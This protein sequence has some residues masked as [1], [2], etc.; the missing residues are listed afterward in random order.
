MAISVS[1]SYCE[2]TRDERNRRKR[3]AVLQVTGLTAGV[4]NIVPH[5]L[6]MN[7]DQFSA[8]NIEPTSA[9]PF[10]EYQPADLTNL[11]IHAGGAGTACNVVVEY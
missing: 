7:P 6:P 10:S 2:A 5:G 11:Y 8:V 1:I 9:G 4:N 3:R